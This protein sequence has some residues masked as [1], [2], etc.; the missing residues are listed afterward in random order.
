L[1]TVGQFLV[2]GFYLQI[3][4]VTKIALVLT[5][6]LHKAL[7]LYTS[8]QRKERHTPKLQSVEGTSSIVSEQKIIDCSGRLTFS[9]S[10]RLQAIN[11]PEETA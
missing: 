1:S 10:K 8:K 3:V 7:Q 11:V 5:F 6:S 4:D 9:R 2:G